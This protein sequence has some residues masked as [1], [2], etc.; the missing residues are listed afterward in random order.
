MPILNRPNTDTAS[1]CLF[2]LLGLE[3][4]FHPC[5]DLC[6]ETM[7]LIARYSRGDFIVVAVLHRK[8]IECS[9]FVHRNRQHDSIDDQCLGQS[10]KVMGASHFNVA[11]RA[12]RLERFL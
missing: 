1:G 6:D 8:R 9:E 5:E 12:N 3:L 2:R 7:Q 11:Q 10:C 4:A